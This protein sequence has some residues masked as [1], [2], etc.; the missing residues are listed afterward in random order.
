[1]LHRL[2]GIVLGGLL[3]DAAPASA[4]PC[5]SAEVD[6]AWAGTDFAEISGD[7]GWFPSNYAAQLRLTG[8]VVGETA[9]GAGA[10]ADACWTQSMTATVDARRDSGW[11][12]VAYG[13]EMHLYAKIDTSILGNAIYW[14]GEIPLPYIP[15]D[16]LLAGQTTFDPSLDG[17]PDAQVSDGTAPITLLSSD[18]IGDLIGVFG[19]SGGLRVTVTPSMV[20]SYRSNQLH[21]GNATAATPTQSIMIPRPNVGFDEALELPMSMDGLI[22]YRPTLTFNARFDVKIL[23]YRV[24][25]WNLFGI[26]L[27]LPALERP[28]TLTSETPAHFALPVLEGIGEGARM[29]FAGNATQSIEIRNRGE[30]ELTLDPASLPPGISAATLTVPP[31]GKAMLQVTAA[32]TAFDEGSATL[33]LASSDPDHAEV[34]IILGKDVGGTDPGMV[35]EPAEGGCTAGGSGSL[36]VGLGLIAL[37]RRQAR[38]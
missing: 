8:R 4:A 28:M 31:G 27:N 33:R 36:L 11:L 26:P 25:D 17:Q 2:T 23:G 5:S 19:I 16:L 3:L 35:E 9:V 18:V 29:D 30:K 37:R 15:R 7:T 20:T 21:L 13:A 1:M 6:L 10:R 22:T 38:S 34:A 12:D 32:E 14:E 24:V